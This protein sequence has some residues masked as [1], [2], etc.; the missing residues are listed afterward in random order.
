MTAEN[1]TAQEESSSATGV[2][3][4]NSFQGA[5]LSHT[6]IVTHTQRAEPQVPPRPGPAETSGQSAQ[7]AAPAVSL[8]HTQIQTEMWCKST[9]PEP[10]A[11]PTEL[12]PSLSSASDSSKRDMATST[13]ELHTHE[14]HLASVHSTEEQPSEGQMSTHIPSATKAGS[15][16]YITESEPKPKPSNEVTRNYI[17]KVGMTTY[18]IVPQKSLDKLRF[19]EVELTLESPSTSATQEV[20][21]GGSEGSEQ[22]LGISCQTTAPPQSANIPATALRSGNSELSHSLPSSPA[23]P[24]ADGS[25]FTAVR[26][27]PEVK[28]KKVPPT[29]RPKPASFRLPQH[30]RTPGS[31]V[32]SAAVRSMSVS[33][34]SSSSTA[35]GGQREALGSPRRESY[36][37]ATQESFP[38]PTPAVQSEEKKETAEVQHV[39]SSLPPLKQDGLERPTHTYSV[40]SS[41]EAEASSRTG[42]PPLPRQMSLPSREPSAGLTLEK[43]RSF[44]APKPYSPNTPSR[45]AQA[46]SSAVKRSNSLTLSPV[47]HYGRKVPLALTQHSSIRESLDMPES[48]T[49]TVSMSFCLC[50]EPLIL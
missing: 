4:D 11:N 6:H 16:Q 32:S 35:A 13:E 21:T 43:L 29:T 26:A 17:P 50:F 45:F 46:V 14:V 28:E 42:H 47:G 24:E 36:P 48:P 33:D 12:I 15:L 25:S 19:F 1:S 20:S 3:E 2:L 37:G 38:P 39:A 40:F 27:G 41:R 30:K 5:A 44:A 23:S 10:S 22:P 7:N 49:T 9:E 18:T 34:S 31:Y 8:T